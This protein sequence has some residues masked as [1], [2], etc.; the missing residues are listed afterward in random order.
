[1]ME[2]PFYLP[3]DIDEGDYIEIGQM[4]A[5]SECLR[6]GFNGYKDYLS[7]DIAE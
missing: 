2:G 7:F 3:K 6:T 1:M 4:G 5:Y